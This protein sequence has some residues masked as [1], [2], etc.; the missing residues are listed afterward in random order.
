M[1]TSPKPAT[2]DLSLR[3]S[4]KKHM[5]LLSFIPCIGS[6]CK[7]FKC[8]RNTQGAKRGRLTKSPSPITL[9]YTSCKKI[10]I[11][12]QPVLVL[13]GLPRLGDVCRR[14][15]AGQTITLSFFLCTSLIN[16][17]GA[18]TSSFLVLLSERA[19]QEPPLSWL[20]MLLLCWPSY[21][22]SLSW[23]YLLSTCM[24]THY[25]TWSLAHSGHWHTLDVKYK[26]LLKLT[27]KSAYIQYIWIYF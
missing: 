1:H 23:C 7:G 10:S 4:E 20:H 3:D 19:R 15:S 14:F 16:T 18:L 5:H 17:T 24:Y 26:F 22:F 12:I 2:H 27:S 8:N 21:R 11:S 25:F 13:E 9:H 6:R